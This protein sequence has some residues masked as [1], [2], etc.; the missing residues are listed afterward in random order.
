M[1][2]TLTLLFCLLALALCQAAQAQTYSI[3]HAF[4]GPDGANPYDGITVDGAGNLYRTTVYGGN[5]CNTSADCGTVFRLQRRGSNWIFSLLYLFQPST[6]G[7]GPSSRVFIG[8]DSSLYGTTSYDR[9]PGCF[10]DDN[11]GCGVLYRLRPS[12]GPCFTALCPWTETVVH[13]FQGG[14]GDGFWPLGDVAFDSAGN[15]YGVTGASGGVPCYGAGT[16]GCGTAYK[17]TPAGGSW[18][19]SIIYSFAADFGV[20]P[21]STGVVMSSSGDLYGTADVCCGPHSCSSDV[22]QLSP[23]G[24]GWS[25]QIIQYFDDHGHGCYLG[26]LI[27]DGAGNIYGMTT[28][29]RPWE[30]YP[31]GEV[32]QLTPSGSG[33][34]YDTVYGFSGRHRDFP[35]GEL[36]RDANGNLYGAVQGLGAYGVGSIFKLSPTPGGWMYTDLHDFNGL[37]GSDPTGAVVLDARGNLYG[38]TYYGGPH[39]AGVVW[40]ITP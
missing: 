10:Y 24:S 3:L 13:S 31:G 21:P 35:A 19:E 18:T 15:I 32:F 8:P 12:P 22:F 9:R 37:D 20:G 33:W 28:F 2:K 26:G 30:P 40:E 25:G 4:S 29:E 16:S 7:F 23:S 27:L 17:V 39:N 36:A 11:N 34:N 1:K 38:T 14:S 5:N 6:N